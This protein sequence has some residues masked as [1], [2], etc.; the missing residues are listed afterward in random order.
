MSKTGL[1]FALAGL[2]LLGGCMQA[3][4]SPSSEAN[5][6]PRDRQLLAH[7]PYAEAKIPEQFQRHIVD[8]DRR[9]A[10]GT[11][12]VDTD[13]RY[14]YYV[15]PN[16][17]AIRYGVAVGEEA[18][19]FSGVATVG[20][21]AEWPDWVPT[22][23][24]Q[25]RLGPYPKRVAGGPANPLGA[26]AIYLYQGNKDTLYRIHGT[27]QPEYIG[28]AISSGCIRMTNTD[29]ADLYSR[30]TTGTTVVVLPPGQSVGGRLFAGRA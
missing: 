12:L 27:N 26:R 22:P 24:I 17:K 8:Y 4:L 15:M 23:E 10:P 20:K 1:A 7:P 29:V 5:F 30:V 19:A 28:Q 2:L 3:T 11:I 18:M 14:L 6:T 25:A 13:A 9:E 16:G 21:M